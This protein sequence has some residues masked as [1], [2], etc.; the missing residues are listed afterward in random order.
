MP[1]FEPKQ[2]GRFY[3]IEKLAVGGMAE[4]YKAKTFGVDGFEKQCAIKRILPHCSADKDFINMLVDEAKLSVLLSHAN[5]VQVYD[6]GKVGDDYFISMEF[7]SGIN[8]RDI[9]YRCREKGI[10]I[11]LDIAVYII[12]EMCKGLDYA[13]RKT[14]ENGSP[15]NIVHRDISPQNVLISYEGEVK[16]VDFGIAK[17]AMNISHTMAGILKGKIAYMSPEQALGKSVDYRTDIYSAGIILYESVTGKKLYTGESQFEV[18]KKIR[19]TKID[20]TK[21]PPEIPHRLQE[22]MAKGLAYFPKDRFQSAGDMQIELT[23]YLYSTYLDFSPQ[24]LAAFVKDIFTTEIEEHKKELI[25]EVKLEAQTSS[26]NI[27]EEALQEDLVQRHET[28]VTLH[29][30]QQPAAHPHAGPVKVKKVKEQASGEETTSGS[31]QK[32]AIEK[33]RRSSSQIIAILA[34]VLI[35]AVAGLGFWKFVYPRLIAKPTPTPIPI[36]VQDF[37]TVNIISNPPGAKVFLDG[38][39]TDQLTPTKLEKLTLK[40]EY[41]VRLTKDNFQETSTTFTLQSPEPVI[42]PMELKPQVPVT[43]PTPVLG[44]V[45]I[46]STPSGASVWLDAIDTGKKTPA[47]LTEL[48]LNQDYK[49]TLKLDKY[50]DIVEPVNLKDA[51][52]K[53]LSLTLKP[54]PVVVKAEPVQEIKE[55]SISVS[56]TPNGASIF[57][58]GKSTGLVTP[59]TIKNLKVGGTYKIGL[60]LKSYDDIVKNITIKTETPVTIQETLK[61][62][63]ETTSATITSNPSGARIFLD[64]RD[65]RRS[66]PSTLSGL[67]A[68]SSHTVRLTKQGFEPTTRSFTT[69]EK[70]TITVAA[71]LKEAA[72]KP[73]PIKPEPIKPEPVKPEPVKP[74]PVKP[75]PIKPEPIKPIK[76]EPTKPEV[77]GT[78]SI[79]V[80]SSPSGA[81]VFINSEYKG[82]TPV[83]VTVPAGTR[84]VVVTKGAGQSFSTTVNVGNGE[85]KSVNA[86]LE[87]TQGDIVVSS[88]P[89]RATVLLDGSPLGKTPLTIRKVSRS[90]GHSISVQ[91]DGYRSQSRSFTF[92]EGDEKKFHF[93]LEEQ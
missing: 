82:T 64:G 19:T 56:S 92:D 68:N 25:K 42:V 86:R 11:P 18:L 66:T 79:R 69:A 47:E 55:S 61:K 50:L 80:T 44:K 65:T 62:S 40:K 83:T 58:D 77:G 21:L 75:E 17:A 7:I 34:I 52:T 8:Y 60:V 26:M 49:I 2:F 41:A 74:E 13:H 51:T 23:K 81:E 37:G 24:K 4:I 67:K 33:S 54:V 15:L 57:L 48:K 78:G 45:S 29:V 93:T 72:V 85:T 46:A 59:N 63:A 31:S 89:S 84:K 35:A 32:I 71:T 28:A 39:D 27:A 20:T 12:S 1:A 88:T 90:G 91:L 3:L 70:Q 5:I 9:M 38:T 73:E 36:A 6:L 16:I 53:Q 30:P 87:S 76:P 43:P 10:K 22:I 14:D